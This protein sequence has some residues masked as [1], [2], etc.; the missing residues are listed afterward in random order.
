M[1]SYFRHPLIFLLPYSKALVNGRKKRIRLLLAIC[2]ILFAIG[3]IFFLVQLYSAENQSELILPAALMMS[4]SVLFF[5]L[6]I[7]F[8]DVYWLFRNDI[9]GVISVL[10]VWNKEKE[11][12]KPRFILKWFSLLI[13]IAFFGELYSARIAISLGA[14]I[15]SLVIGGLIVIGILL[16]LVHLIWHLNIKY[17]GEVEELIEQK[18]ITLSKHNSDSL[19]GKRV[20]LTGRT[21]HTSIG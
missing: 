14:S 8:W 6:E 5:A 7:L 10:D 9:D 21:E 19:T 16:S 3:W 11:K 4:L 20:S 1:P 15:T 17:Q 18:F 12:G 13:F 2:N